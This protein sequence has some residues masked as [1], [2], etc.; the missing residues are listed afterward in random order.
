MIKLEELEKY[1]ALKTVE[2]EN[3]EEMVEDMR[4]RLH[5]SDNGK[6]FVQIVGEA[7]NNGEPWFR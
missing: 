2:R 5:S 3:M 1:R 7:E 6:L 4:V